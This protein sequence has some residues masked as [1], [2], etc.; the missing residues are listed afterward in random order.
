MFMLLWV[1]EPVC[2]MA[3]GIRRVF[4]CQHFV[5]GVDDGGGFVC[6]QQA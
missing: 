2:Q 1:P 5:G 6:R 4:A 3:R